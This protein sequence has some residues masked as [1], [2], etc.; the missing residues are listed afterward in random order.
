[1]VPPLLVDDANEE[2]LTRL[3]PW[4]D[5]LQAL[6]PSQK[7]LAYGRDLRDSLN[8]EEY[9]SFRFPA[10]V[11]TPSGRMSVT[12]SN[13]PERFHLYVAYAPDADPRE[14]LINPYAA[15]DLN[16]Q[17]WIAIDLYRATG[18]AMIARD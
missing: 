11:F 12:G 7:Y 13:T 10:H 8:I 14:R 6:P 9:R 18:R 1:V 4:L 15:V 3:P 16:N 5:Y 17:R 2:I